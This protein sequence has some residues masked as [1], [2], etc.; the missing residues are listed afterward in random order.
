LPFSARKCK[1][2][3][4][5]HPSRSTS[6][7]EHKFSHMDQEN[8][9]RTN[10][11]TKSSHTVLYIIIF[12]LLIAVVALSITSVCLFKAQNDL[13]Q[14]LIPEET[15]EI[16]N[17]NS[18]LNYIPFEPVTADQIYRLVENYEEFDLEKENLLVA[19][20]AF[21]K[22]AETKEIYYRVFSHPCDD[23]QNDSYMS[24]TRGGF[25]T[26]RT[27]TGETQDNP[28]N[29]V[30]LSR[31]E[32]VNADDFKV[33]D[34]ARYATDGKYVYAFRAAFEF[35]DVVSGFTVI[36]NVDLAS[37][38]I[39]NSYYSKD[40][41]QV[42][43]TSLRETEG[44]RLD[45]DTQEIIFS[46]NMIVLNADP[47]TF[48]LYDRNMRMFGITLDKN[49]VYLGDKIIP[50]ADPGSFEIIRD[51]SAFGPGT[52]YARDDNSVFID[53]CLLSGVQPDEFFTPEVINSLLPLGPHYRNNQLTYDFNGFT[54]EFESDK[55][56]FT[57]TCRLM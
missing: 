31:L 20:G 10:P 29:L 52:I 53:Y 16:N 46:A 21:Y 37:F 5:L 18:N 22:N 51:F 57:D 23:R 15:E 13:E 49:N 36:P 45:S 39:L 11:S 34:T 43:K 42:F 54:I 28:Y 3:L 8:I 41:N 2:N 47:E 33:L 38:E 26:L 32:G 17:I 24:T 1:R 55:Q 19:G 35:C 14:E 6:A 25:V 9:G 4:L 48:R 56:Q 30:R 50:N 7:I 27:T 44:R 40:K 12:I